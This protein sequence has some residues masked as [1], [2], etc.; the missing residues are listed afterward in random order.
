MGAGPLAPDGV[1]FFCKRL[2][3]EL[4][5]VRGNLDESTSGGVKVGPVALGAASGKEGEDVQ[6]VGSASLHEPPGSLMRT[7]GRE[8]AGAGVEALGP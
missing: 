5:L 2:L 1:V 6:L 8:P 3:G 7:G 4:A